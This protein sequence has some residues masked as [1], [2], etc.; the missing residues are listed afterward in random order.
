MHVRYR[1]L[2]ISL[3]GLVLVLIVGERIL[4][5]WLEKQIRRR[6]ADAHVELGSV[7][8]SI[9]TRSARLSNIRWSADTIPT[10]DSVSSASIEKLTIK[11]IRIYP[12][13]SDKRIVVRSVLIENGDL[14]MLYSP[15]RQKTNTDTVATFNGINIE[16]IHLTN[17]TFSVATDSL[18]TWTGTIDIKLGMVALTDP[19]NPL[20]LSSY[21]AVYA[22]L[23]LD[24]AKMSEVNGYNDLQI[25]HLSFDRHRKTLICDSIV[26]TPRYS[27][28]EY[29]RKRG[30]QSTW[31]AVSIPRIE[32]T[33]LDLKSHLDTTFTATRITIAHARIDAFRDRRVPLLRKTQ[34][35][36]PMSAF[37][38]LAFAVEIDSIVVD[39]MQVVYEHFAEE[40]FK[41]GLI[42]FE[43]LNGL[44]LNV[45]NREYDNVPQVTTLDATT[46][47]MGKGELKAHFD[48]PLSATARYRAKGSVRELP[49]ASLNPILE[50]AVFISIES[51]DLQELQFEFTYNNDRSEGTLE[52]DYDNLK[53]NGLTKDRK[54]DTDQFKTLIANIAIRNKRARAGAISAERDKRRFIIHFWAASLFDGIKNAAVPAAGDK[55]ESK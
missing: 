52:I 4:S 10:I 17:T 20:R 47:I 8:V 26:V 39:D 27:K 6:A 46:R 25:G 22:D 29:A 14:Q 40:A 16:S 42:R 9:F 36:M 51:G 41:P 1:V 2:L 12:F 5:A 3:A 44:F 43:K 50:H 38:K 45:N 35:P 21:E 15:D 54:A 33:G 49:L 7:S 37:R 31:T 28:V 11:G 18:T 19:G 55:K 34:I 48:F 30:T 32:V 23:E 13:V 24:H 53:I